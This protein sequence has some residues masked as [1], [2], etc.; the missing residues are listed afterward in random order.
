MF[1]AFAPAFA[2][3][4]FW[5]ERG[6]R[7]PAIHLPIISCFNY[8][9]ERLE[10]WYVLLSARDGEVS[11]ATSLPETP[12]GVCPG[13]SW[14]FFTG[15]PFM[16]Q[17]RTGLLSYAFMQNFEPVFNAQGTINHCAFLGSFS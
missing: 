7:K 11:D 17:V 6:R 1:A 14:P 4:R 10:S 8:K 15:T 12:L 16:T 3:S 9:A 2:V 13:L 5:L